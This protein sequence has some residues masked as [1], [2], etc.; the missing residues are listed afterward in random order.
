VEKRIPGSMPVKSPSDTIGTQLS[1]A[2][3]E[4]RKYAKRVSP[5]IERIWRS[6]RD[7]TLGTVF[8]PASKTRRIID[9]LGNSTQSKVRRRACNALR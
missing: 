2:A 6:S 1:T 4:S 3:V 8:K 5:E 9:L 7:G